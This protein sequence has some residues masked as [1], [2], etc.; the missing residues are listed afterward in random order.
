[1]I[2][3]RQCF[4][5]VS[6]P[7]QVESQFLDATTD[8]QF[9]QT[10]A[11]LNAAANKLNS[12]T[13]LFVSVSLDSI[14]KSHGEK[15]EAMAEA[16]KLLSKAI[17]NLNAAAQKASDNVLVVAATSQDG[18]VK[19]QKRATPTAEVNMILNI[20]YTKQIIDLDNLSKQWFEIINL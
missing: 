8:K 14:V 16:K 7:A 3:Y 5:D 12:N 17:T 2:N 18:A 15:S 10:L 6:A 20:I 19:R 4:G 9:L 11:Y 1:M 13:K